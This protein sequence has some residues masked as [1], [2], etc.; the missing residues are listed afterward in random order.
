MYSPTMDALVSV[1]HAR[2]AVLE[3]AR[4]TGA[5]GNSLRDAVGRTLAADVVSPGPLPPFDMSAMD[6]VAVRLSDLSELPGTLPLAG[7]IHAGDGDPPPLPPGSVVAVMTGAVLPAG[8]EAVVPVEWTAREG[9]A[10]RIERAP[11]AG[12]FVRQRGEALAEGAV[13]L[14][15]GETVTPGAVGLLAAVGAATVEVRKKPSLAVIATGDEIVGAAETPGP[16]QIRDANG[17]GLAAQVEAAG[18]AV[19]GPFV[20]RDTAASLDATLDAVAGADVLLFAGG[21]SMGERDLVRQ[22][23]DARGCR[24]SAWGVAQRPGK[25]LAV[26]ALGERPVI[27]L[28]GNPVSAAVCFEVYVRP[29][30]SRMLG[31]PAEPAL[32]PAVLDAPIPKAEGLHTFARVTAQ[33]DEAGILRLRPAGAQGSHVAFSLAHADGLAHLPAGW[34][35]APAGAAVD[36]QPWRW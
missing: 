20:A 25:P 31:G 36:F 18:G 23:L 16:G 30:L 11:E 32:E 35:D 27:G 34:R 2:R 12:Q 8:A 29:L 22:T 17:P 26:G 15:A 21:V 24:W 19:A 14:R 3:M 4:P 33:R 1:A 28:P 13:V 6:G 10:V 7:T 5:E 9:D